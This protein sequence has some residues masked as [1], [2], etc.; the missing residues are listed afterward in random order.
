M[1]LSLPPSLWERG[2]PASLAR[3]PSAGETAE[4]PP[5]FLGFSTVSTVR[6]FHSESPAVYSFSHSPLFRPQILPK[7]LYFEE[8]NPI[9]FDRDKPIEYAKSGI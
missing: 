7:T 9:C 3:F 8:E 1:R 5:L 2:N 4:K 6:H